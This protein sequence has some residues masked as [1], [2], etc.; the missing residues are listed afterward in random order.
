M[1]LE[2]ILGESLNYR[3]FENDMLNIGELGENEF[4]AY[5]P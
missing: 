2:V 4:I 5:N 1:P 3:N